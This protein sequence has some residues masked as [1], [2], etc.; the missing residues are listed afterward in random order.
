MASLVKDKQGNFLVAFRLAKQQ[1]TRS[2]ET[3]ESEVALAAVA[4]GEETIMRLK[5]GW[6]TMPDGAE[7]GAFITSCGTMTSKPAFEVPKVSK[8]HTPSGVFAV[9]S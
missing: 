9:G 3:I 2:L 7:P 8:A 4:R 5:R 6:L 1:F